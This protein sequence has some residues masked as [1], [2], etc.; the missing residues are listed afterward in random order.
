MAACGNYQFRRTEI[1]RDARNR[2]GELVPRPMVGTLRLLG[3]GRNQKF[4]QA[5][6][7]GADT[8]TQ[9]MT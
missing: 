7:S 2:E 4:P 9:D 6:P 1:A 3:R 8:C 5:L